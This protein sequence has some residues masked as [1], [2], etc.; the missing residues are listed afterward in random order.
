MALAFENQL[1]RREAVELP[2]EE[3]LWVQIGKNKA[4]RSCFPDILPER[5]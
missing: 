2:F 3:S 1:W 5:S 4:K